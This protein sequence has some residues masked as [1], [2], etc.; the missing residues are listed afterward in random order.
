MLKSEQPKEVQQ[1][2]LLRGSF[3]QIIGK[4]HTVTGSRIYSLAGQ[5][6]GS[7]KEIDKKNANAHTEPTASP[8]MSRGNK[9]TSGTNRS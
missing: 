4:S 6:G 1:P 3:T 5:A 7:K 2:S 9:A 8:T